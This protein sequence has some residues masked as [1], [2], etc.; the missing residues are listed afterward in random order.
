LPVTPKI[1]MLTPSA[2]ISRVAVGPSMHGMTK[3]IKMASNLR[4]DGATQH[5]RVDETER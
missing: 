3:S 2:R 5:S 4:Q 1:G